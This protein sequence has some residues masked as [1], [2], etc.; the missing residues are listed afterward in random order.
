MGLSKFAKVLGEVDR[1]RSSEKKI[2]VELL[3]EE[4]G[5]QQNT[6][7]VTQRRSKK[8]VPL[9][10]VDRIAAMFEPGEVEVL[11]D[12]DF[13]MRIL[14]VLY[15]ALQ[16]L[17]IEKLTPAEIRQVLQK[18][19]LWP[20]FG[21]NKPQANYYKL[22]YE[23]RKLRNRGL[24][25]ISERGAGGKYLYSITDEGVDAIEVFI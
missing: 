9:T 10:Q 17:E 21:R 22:D 15:V 7:A 4:V 6:V 2:L 25:D 23:L 8:Q 20:R 24:V 11:K 18:L 5:L 12:C 1:L 14:A 19:Q 3:S 16:Q 13:D